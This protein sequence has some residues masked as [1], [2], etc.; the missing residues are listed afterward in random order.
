MT[1][2]NKFE[3]LEKK[4]SKI[5]SDTSYTS[6]SIA[7]IAGFILTFGSLW[8]YGKTHDKILLIVG[9]FFGIMLILSVIMILRDTAF[10]E[11]SI[12]ESTKTFCPGCGKQTKKT[13][14]FCEHCGNKVLL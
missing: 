7:I 13:A 11:V 8:V 6:W 1:E 12:S 14:K 5:E 10:K 3:E 2:K 9:S 4:I